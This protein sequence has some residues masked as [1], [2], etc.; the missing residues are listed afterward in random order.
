MPSKRKNRK[1]AIPD[2]Y[3]EKRERN[4]EAVRKSRAKAKAKAEQTTNRITKLRAENRLLE[5]RKALLAKELEMLKQMFFRYS[6][7]KLR[8]YKMIF[9]HAILTI[10]SLFIKAM[11]RQTRRATRLTRL[12]L[13]CFKLYIQE[14][15][16][17][18][19]CDDLPLKK[20]FVKHCTKSDV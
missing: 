16:I 14:H 9:A 1:S 3:I 4:N 5:E 15:S 19:S 8:V 6:Q 7:S 2:E 10:S 18:S 17:L 20:L 12:H 13:H 11:K